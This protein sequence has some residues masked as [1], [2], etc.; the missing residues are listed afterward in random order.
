MFDISSEALSVLEEILISQ[1]E[2][3]KTAIN[4]F[5]NA[6]PQDMMEIF[7][8]LFEQENYLAKRESMKIV[9]E[10]LLNKEILSEFYAYFVSEKEHLKFTMISLNDESPAINFEAFYMLIIFIKAPK[11][12]RGPKVNETLLKNSDKLIDFITHFQE[13]KTDDENLSINKEI[14]IKALKKI[15][16]EN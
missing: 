3:V 2:E 8:F 15:Q 14:A 6:H 16:K 10:L 5:L 9:H 1:N 13:E 7:L 11:D 12:I 4:K